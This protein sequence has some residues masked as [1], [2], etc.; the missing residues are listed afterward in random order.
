[1]KTDATAAAQ[2]WA[3]KMA[4]A[5][6]FYTAGVQAVQE[7]PGAAAARQAQVAAQNYQARIN[8]GS[9][10]KRVGAVTLG[11]WQQAAITKGAPR[12][13]SGAQAAQPKVQAFLTDF[14]PFEQNVVN[15]VKSSMPRGTLEQNIARATAVMQGLS[16]FR[17]R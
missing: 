4:G 13:A 8:D 6:Q 16:K 12:L 3:T 14:L 5:S 15:Q 1:M 17:Q 7:A 2:K 9:W 11:S 10:A